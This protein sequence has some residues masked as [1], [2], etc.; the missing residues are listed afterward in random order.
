MEGNLKLTLSI[1][2]VLLSD[3]VSECIGMAESAARKREI[4]LSVLPFD[5]AWLI[6]A[7]KT[8]FKQVLNNLISNA[9]KYNKRQGTVAVKCTLSGSERVRISV[10]DNGIGIPPEKISHL[11]QPF[12]RLGRLR[13]ETTTA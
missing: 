5:S 6:E 10:K 7:D 12:N 13:K 1:E 3:I 4:H 2:P 8:R 11:F 9:I